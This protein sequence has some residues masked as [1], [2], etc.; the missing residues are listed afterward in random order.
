M[1]FLFI[2]D[3]KSPYGR[4]DRTIVRASVWLTRCHGPPR[5]VPSMQLDILDVFAESPLAGNQLAVVR[6]A[7]E[8]T[9]ERM[10]AMALEMNFSET[11][12]VLAESKDRARVRIFT[13]TQELPFAGH[14]TLGTAWALGGDRAEYTLEL[15]AGNVCVE[16]EN[17]V[18]WMRPPP[19]ALHENHSADEVARWLG[20][21]PADID[22]GFR[23]Q[24]GDVGVEFLLVG[25]ASLETLENL[26]VTIDR[27][28]ALPAFALYAF[29]SKTHSPEADFRARMFFD[30]GGLREDPATGSAN[31]VFGA[32]LM[33]TRGPDYSLTVD[34]GVEMGRPSRIYLE[35]SAGELRVG[36][37]V[38][39]VVTGQWTL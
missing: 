30:A 17:G 12:F 20:L 1:N 2:S 31:S 7:S 22:P 5:F 4:S 26:E 13:P 23:A 39:R 29:T 34:Q 8:L 27:L 3:R 15:D 19:I 37:K 14:P 10:Q 35:S 33:Q 11:T 38:R 32:Y 21:H 25:L 6:G 9:S 36:G 18:A 28:R 24:R 16:F